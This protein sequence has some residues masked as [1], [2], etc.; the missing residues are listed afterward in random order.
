MLERMRSCLIKRQ[1]AASA[2]K[3]WQSRQQPPQQL[4]GHPAEVAATPGS[5]GSCEAAA[6]GSLVGHGLARGGSCSRL[7][8]TV[9]GLVPGRGLHHHGAKEEMAA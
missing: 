4:R 3:H 7:E 8:L 5:R 9:M 6:A 1:L 2:W